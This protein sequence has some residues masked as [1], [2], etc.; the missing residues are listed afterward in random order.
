MPSTASGT[1]WERLGRPGRWEDKL[2]QGRGCVKGLEPECKGTQ[3][4]RSG[5]I[6]SDRGSQTPLAEGPTGGL[7]G[8]NIGNA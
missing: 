5:I 3:D 1:E 7:E 2:P 4:P 8:L 6:P